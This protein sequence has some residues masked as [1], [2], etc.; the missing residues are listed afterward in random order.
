[1]N[2]VTDFLEL[3]KIFD[4]VDNDISKN[5]AFIRITDV[6]CINKISYQI[7]NNNVQESFHVL[8]SSASQELGENYDFSTTTYSDKIVMVRIYRYQYAAELGELNDHF[9][10][11]AQIILNKVASSEN[12]KSFNSIYNYDQQFGI[13]NINS[14]NRNVNTII[15]QGNI[16]NYHVVY[17]NIINCRTLNSIFGG[18]IADSIIQKLCNL[19][20]SYVDENDGE[21]FSRLGGDNFLL[22]LKDDKVNDVISNIKTVRI[23]SEINNDY[24]DYT[25]NTRIGLVNLYSN[26]NSVS[27]ILNLASTAYGFAKLPENSNY[28]I[29]DFKAKTSDIEEESY[30][31]EISTA[32]KEEKFLVYYQPIVSKNNSDIQLFSA[33]ALI[34]WRR[35]G[36]MLNP[37]T[38]IQIADKYNLM[39]D[40]DLFVL[41]TVCKKL[42]SWIDEGISPVCI[43]CNFADSDLLANNLADRIIAIIDEHNIHHSL[44]NIEFAESAYHRNKTAFIYTVK[45]LYEKGI[46]VSIDNFGRSFTSLELF[47]YVDFSTLK[48]DSTI[49]NSDQPKSK[50]LLG[51]LISLADKLGIEVVCEGANTINEIENAFTSGC[52]I[53]QTEV[54]EKA[55]SERY[56]VNRLKNPIYDL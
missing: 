24:I 48:I 54:F 14:F 21:I 3:V 22:L 6:L 31:E 27:Q 8:F 12:F 39:V 5:D 17:F 26:N 55:L 40:I 19:V 47:E 50:I 23:S 42:S 49:V 44:I 25:I 53:F 38:F 52:D 2:F 56:F 11:F 30:A 10:F 41:K 45:K 29:L 9:R 15:S 46:K 32:L 7:I 13:Y 36:E 20:S 16:E 43:H 37:K 51:S 18:V 1:M 28:Y 4:S 33:E 35:S 34:R